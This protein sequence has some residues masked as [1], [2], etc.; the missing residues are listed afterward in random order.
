MNNKIDH[1]VRACQNNQ[2]LCRLIIDNY[3][4]L[5]RKNKKLRH[6]VKYLK[7]NRRSIDDEYP[8]IRVKAVPIKATRKINIK[9]I[10]SRRKNMLSSYYNRALN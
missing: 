2:E 5:I 6:Q 4:K 9:N 7:R 10:L 8:T 3:Y 1:L